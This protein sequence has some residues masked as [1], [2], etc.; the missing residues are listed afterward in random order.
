MA[1]SGTLLVR[2]YTSRAEI[3]V[4]GA[5]VIVASRGR[6]GK[7]QLISLQETD[8][9]GTIKPVRVDAPPA[10]ESTS[11]DQMEQPFAVVDVWVEHPG[12]EVM[13]LEEVQVFAGQ[14]TQQQVELNPLVAGESWTERTAVRPIPPQEL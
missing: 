8:D 7:Y 12:Y 13:W 9:S 1:Q 4:V 3:P 11:P 6:D 2:V 5:A 10:G 14:Q